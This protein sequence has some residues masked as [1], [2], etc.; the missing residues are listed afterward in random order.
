MKQK[1]IEGIMALGYKAQFQQVTKNGVVKEGILIKESED[2]KIAP[3]IYFDPDFENVDD[4]IN[5]IVNLYETHK[6]PKIDLDEFLCID[7]IA[8]NLRVGFQQAG[9]E[10]IV[11]RRTIFDGIE[12]YLYI[13][14]NMEGDNASAK[15]KPAML[16]QYKISDEDA[17][18]LAYINTFQ[19]TKVTTLAEELGFESDF[20]GIP[21]MYIVTNKNHYKGAANI[22]DVKALEQ[23]AEKYGTNKMVAIPAS[24]H[25]FIVLPD[26]FRNMEEIHQMVKEV[27]TN[28]VIPEEVLSNRGYRI[29]VDKEVRVG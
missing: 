25:E 24:I 10:P 2:T 12:A 1:V 6:A 5:R 3:V 15:V 20:L 4:E 18:R 21:P 7:K 16:T 28:D 19:N 26:D 8:D 14:V 13:S 22:L 17:W 9:D 29:T 11:K 23:I 27:N